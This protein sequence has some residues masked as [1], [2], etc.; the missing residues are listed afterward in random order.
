MHLQEGLRK[1]MGTLQ[2]D[3]Q[4][5]FMISGNDACAAGR[6]R[7]GRCTRCTEGGAEEG[8]HSRARESPACCTDT[9]QVVH[10]LRRQA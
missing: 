2:C 4:R 3:L 5:H 7:F 6:I 8:T 10:A 9:C 1:E